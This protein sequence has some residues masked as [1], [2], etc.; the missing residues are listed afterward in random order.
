MNGLPFGNAI[1]HNSLQTSLPKTG[2]ITIGN[3]FISELSFRAD[4]YVR[5]SYLNVWSFELTRHSV[6]AM[7]AG[8]LNINGDVMAWRNV[9]K[10]I[11]G[12]IVIQ[13]RVALY[14]PG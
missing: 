12:N 13:K 9:H 14:F 2:N 6:F 11:V 3:N 7:S 5:I 4:A 10:S 8:G 1:E